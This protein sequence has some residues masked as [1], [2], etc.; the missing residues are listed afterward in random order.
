MP[1]PL[2]AIFGQGSSIVVHL[3]NDNN[4]VTF[5]RMREEGKQE[6]ICMSGKTKA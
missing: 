1:L 3:K 6:A 2:P 4:N 5:G